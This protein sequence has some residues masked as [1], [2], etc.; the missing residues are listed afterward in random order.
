MTVTERITLKRAGFT[1]R[2]ISDHRTKFENLLRIN[3]CL[4]SELEELH[5]LRTFVE[6]AFVAHPNLDIDVKVGS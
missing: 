3:P 4:T 1:D 5:T 6:K 2:Q